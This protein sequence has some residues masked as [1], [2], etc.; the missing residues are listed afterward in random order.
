[1]WVGDRLFTFSTLWVFVS[2]CVSRSINSE[3]VN[4]KSIMTRSC[5]F[6]KSTLEGK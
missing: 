6:C 3:G 2:R 1:M 4:G 5:V